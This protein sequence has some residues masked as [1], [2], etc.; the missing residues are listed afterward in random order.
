MAPPRLRRPGFSRRAQYGLFAAYVIAVAGIVVALLLLVAARFDPQGFSALRATA[1]DLAAPATS[2]GRGLVDGATTIGEEIGAYWRA[3]TQNAEL[4]RE[5]EA[6][7]A[8]L[9]EARAIDFENR[10][11][12]RLLNLVGDKRE[13]VAV[14]RVIGSSASSTR[15]LVTLSAGRTAGV[16]PGQPIRSAEG[17][18][19]R[20]VEAGQIS[21]R[22]LLITDGS[23]VV[24]VQI[25]RSGVAAL[26]T[27]QGDGSIELRSLI[28]GA[29]PFRRGDVVM[30]TGAG[31]IYP[32]GIPVA[33][34][35]KVTRDAAR[36]MPLAD[37]ARLDF[38][39]VLRP[40]QSDLPPPP[41]APTGP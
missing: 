14:V 2:A 10:R 32:A 30:T 7:R 24:P 15:R 18:I 28:A 21:S 11:L 5:I 27:G 25:I 23:S 22:A 20:V 19:G 13:T 3:G 6:S 33:V 12:K 39:M 34:V 1:N 26:A 9:V 37:P 4:R 41:P 8:K 29:S 38:A 40:L 36:A 35:T 17:L 16:E 31:G